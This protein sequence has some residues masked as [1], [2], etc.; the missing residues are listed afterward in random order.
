MNKINPQSI[1][2]L[3]S[4]FKE[5]EWLKY[6]EF[7]AFKERV[8]HLIDHL[9]ATEFDLIIEL[10]E[11]YVWINSN[12]Y[13][14]RIR[15]LFLMFYDAYLIDKDVSTVFLFPILKVNDEGKKKS[16][17]KVLDIIKS[18]V[19]NNRKFENVEFIYYSK[20]EEL[21]QLNLNDNQI[22]M[23]VDDYIG[24]GSTLSSTREEISRNDNINNNYIVLSIIIQEEALNNLENDGINIIFDKMTRKGL[25][26][27]YFKDE[28]SENL[29]LMEKL[30]D[31]IPKV[32]GYRLGY[33]KTEAL[34]TMERTPNN[35]FPIFWKDYRHRKDKDI[36]PAP[37]PRHKEHNYE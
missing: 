16:G 21:A 36:Y 25:T 11:R 6:P 12:G 15:N 5:K 30:E 37:F 18:I 3:Y 19:K 13:H 8:D 28:L 31:Y 33:K 22:L 26:N 29:K 34:V 2:R 9:Q 1:I 27:Y 17:H 24:S 32:R 14:A 20:F 7:E 4:I 10:F 23:L 35:T